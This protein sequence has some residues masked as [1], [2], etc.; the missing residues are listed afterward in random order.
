MTRMQDAGLVDGHRKPVIPDLFWQLAERWQ[1]VPND[2]RTYP[3]PGVVRA[4]DEALR[5]GMNNVAETTGW[6]LTDTMAAAAYGAPIGVRSD[7]PPDFY[8]PDQTSMRRALH[9]LGMASSHESRAATVR[10]AP[11]ALVCTRRIDWGN[12]T[13]PLA[14]PLFVA[15]DPGRGREVLTDWTPPTEAGQRVW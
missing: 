11:S 1:A 15:L 4:T 14:R 13:W 3:A 7:H 5:L 8:L 6:A 2:V 9:L 12:E 10:V